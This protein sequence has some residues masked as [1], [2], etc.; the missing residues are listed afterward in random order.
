M[1][2]DVSPLS[3]QFC[4][5]HPQMSDGVIKVPSTAA[6]HWETPEGWG[7]METEGNSGSDL[8][9]EPPLLMFLDG[10]V[11]TSI[12]HEGSQN[13]PHDPQGGGLAVPQAQPETMGVG[14]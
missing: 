3:G 8:P 6:L 10:E 9:W 14:G 2:G 12:L 13:P 5:L 4:L 11:R 7:R 1:T